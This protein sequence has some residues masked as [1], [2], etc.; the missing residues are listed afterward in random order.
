MTDNRSGRAQ[1]VTAMLAVLV[2]MIAITLTAYAVGARWPAHPRQHRLAPG[3]A[4]LSGE[5][6]AEL[7]PVQTDLPPGWTRYD[8]P[9]RRT[10]AAGFG[11]HRY[12]SNGVDWGYQPAECIDV[13]YGNGHVTPSPAAEFAQ[14]APGHPTEVHQVADLQI[15]IS[16]EFNPALFTDML[17]QVSRCRRFIARQPFGTARF[18][19][20]VLEDSHPLHGPHRFRY[21][22]TVTYSDDDLLPSET[23]YVSYARTSRLVVAA[24]DSSGNPQLLDTVF[25]KALHQICTRATES[26]QRC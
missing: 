19:V 26:R 14:Y 25:D 7:L 13:R 4:A 21:A 10:P 20:R 16:R 22:V 24:S 6:L 2:M 11:Y 12:H 8:D 18:T 5:R 9:Y 23:R 1:L 3:L 17:A 15:Q